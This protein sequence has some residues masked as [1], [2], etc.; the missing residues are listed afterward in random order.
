MARPG[1]GAHWVCLWA[2]PLAG[3]WLVSKSV[4]GDDDTVSWRPVKVNQGHGCRG[5]G[6][7]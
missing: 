5:P 7:L 6:G 1:F 3:L 2:Q 4:T